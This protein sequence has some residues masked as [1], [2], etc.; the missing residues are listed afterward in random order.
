VKTFIFSAI[1]ASALFM[2]GSPAQAYHFGSTYGSGYGGGYH[3]GSYAA[4][5]PYV[6]VGSYDSYRG[7][8]GYGGGYRIRPAGYRTYGYSTPRYSSGY[9][10]QS[11]GLRTLGPSYVSQPYTLPQQTYRYPTYS[12]GYSS[13]PYAVPS[14]YRYNTGSYSYGSSYGTVNTVPYTSTYPGTYDYRC[15]C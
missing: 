1:A 11:Y 14:S 13:R 4:P 3:G 12:S 9:G 2:A 6:N 15:N 10:S 5:G 7:H 8:A